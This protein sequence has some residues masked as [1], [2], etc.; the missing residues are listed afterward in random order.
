MKYFI[1]LILLGST[2]NTSAQTSAHN[3]IEKQYVYRY[4]DQMPTAP[5]DI[6]EYLKQNMRYPAQARQEGEK[7]R[8][9]VDFVMQANGKATNI[10][11]RNAHRYPRIAE[12]AKRLIKDMPAWNPGKKEGKPVHV[13]MSQTVV[14]IP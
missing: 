1:I 13:A 3:T 8:V 4:V 11:A 9:I 5:Y 14:F 6:N 7:G 12:E 10:T 2:M